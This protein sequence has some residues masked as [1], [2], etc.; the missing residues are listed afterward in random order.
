[1]PSAGQVV[2]STVDISDELARKQNA[3]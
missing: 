1:V 3:L 2:L